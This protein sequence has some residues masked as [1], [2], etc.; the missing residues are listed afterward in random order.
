M[1]HSQGTLGGFNQPNTAGSFFPP[2]VMI[3]RLPHA[4]GS[5]FAT[6]VRQPC[7][8]IDGHVK[9][10]GNVV[11]RVQDRQLPPRELFIIAIL[12]QIEVSTVTRV[13]KAER[14]AASPLQP[15]VIVANAAW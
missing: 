7:E 3:V 8:A 11:G 15:G 4:F 1:N 14:A 9:P 10:L 2:G 12:S 6:L 5:A 13:A